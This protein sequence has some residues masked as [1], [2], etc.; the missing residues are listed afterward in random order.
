M[1]KERLT[2]KEIDFIIY[3]SRFQDNQGKI[4]G[5]HYKDV[6]KKM[7]MSYQGFYDVKQSLVKKNIISSEKNNRIDH[8]ITILNNAFLSEED[9][10]NGYI[11]TNHNIFFNEEFYKLKAGSKLLAMEI[12]KLSYSGTG[13]CKIG[14]EKFY[15]KYTKIFC[16]TKRVMRTYLMEL[17]QFFSIGIKNGLYYMRPKSEVYHKPYQPTENDNYTTHNVDVICRR[18]KIKDSTEKERK[19]ICSLVR[20]Y[21]KKAQEVNKNIIELLKMAVEKSLELINTNKPK[22]TKRQL[23]PKL[24]H[25]ILKE[26][27][28][29]LQKATHKYDYDKLEEMLI[30]TTP[31]M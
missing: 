20:Q 27:I 21:K 19:D 5:I 4:A 13:E 28:S 29:R 25:K 8:D 24:V 1:I 17:K 18:N 11:N 23:K 7:N 26:E 3:I 16:V 12:M 15:E 22:I 14:T 2:S 30:N 10:R 6:C 31:V 9:I